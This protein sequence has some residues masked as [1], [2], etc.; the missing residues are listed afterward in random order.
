M[1]HTPDAAPIVD[2]KHMARGK[3]LAKRLVG[4]LT[5]ED[6]RSALVSLLIAFPMTTRA[7]GLA[8]WHCF[9][10]MRVFDRM[11]NGTPE[12]RTAKME[13]DQRGLVVVK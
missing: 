2:E 6:P 12:E 7:C 4:I 3:E 11:H 13:A 10:A 1:L 9:E 5:Q 8:V